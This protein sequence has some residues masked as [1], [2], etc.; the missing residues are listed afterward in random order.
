LFAGQARQFQQGS[1][2]SPDGTSHLKLLGNPV[3]LLRLIAVSLCLS[4]TVGFAAEP[5]ITTKLLTSATEINAIAIRTIHHELHASN[6]AAASL[7]AE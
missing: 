5:P 3:M 2:F 1:I 4:S 6:A 7:L